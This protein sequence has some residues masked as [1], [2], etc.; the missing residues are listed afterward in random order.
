MAG[1]IGSKVIVAIN[2]DAEA[3]IFKVSDFGVVGDYRQV[4]PPL[5]ERLKAAAG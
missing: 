5:I 1:C 3:N 4:L 2:R